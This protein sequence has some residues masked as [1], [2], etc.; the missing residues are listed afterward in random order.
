ML[1][2]HLPAADQ[3]CTQWKLR[4]EP[5]VARA[6]KLGRACYCHR[7]CAR[8]SIVS[9]PV[10]PSSPR[11]C[12]HRLHARTYLN[13]LPSLLPLPC[14]RFIIDI[15]ISRNVICLYDLKP[16]PLSM[17]LLAPPWRKWCVRSLVNYTGPL[18]HLF[19][20]TSWSFAC[21]LRTEVILSVQ[22]VLPV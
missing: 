2:V 6:I 7:S 5:V 3:P 20:C 11:P 12:L 22:P 18:H 4:E 8:A 10:P 9:S 21:F 15:S 13:P 14:H 16:S 19:H 17:D 1:Q